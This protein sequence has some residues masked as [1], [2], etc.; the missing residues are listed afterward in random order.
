VLRDN[1][2]VAG[3][4]AECLAGLDLLREATERREAPGRVGEFRLVREVGRGGMGVVYEAVQE[5]LGRTVAVKVLTLAAGAD[6]AELE[7]FRNE[8]RAAAGLDHPNI[9]PVYA[10]GCDRGVHY[11]AMRLIPGRSLA[12]VIAAGPAT[13]ERPA[14]A[15]R[16]L[17]QAAD[18]LA[19]AH[20]RG[21]VH[22]DVKPANLLVEDGGHVW[23]ADFGLALLPGAAR[24]TRSGSM[25][26]TLQYMSPEQVEPRR[27]VVD[28]RTDLYALGATTYEL[29]TGRPPVQAT[30]RHELVVRILTADATP[31]RRL[32]RSVP[33]DLETIVLKLLAKDPADRY[34]SAADLADDVRRFQGGRPVSSS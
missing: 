12:E 16:V 10:V 1:P 19:F 8:A 32:N 34:A 7:R 30:D 13:G 25:V 3:P 22:R 9:I 24:L 23:V 11:Y 17:L 18:A 28:H 31:P 27:G 5:P 6:P 29:L 21:I 20:A 14:L 2:E 15:A 4:L 26:G 33:A